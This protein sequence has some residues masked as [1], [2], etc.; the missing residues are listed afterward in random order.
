M[1]LYSGISNEA[2]DDCRRKLRPVAAAC[3]H[4]RRFLDRAGNGWM[5]IRWLFR[6]EDGCE[7]VR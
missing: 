4:V 5:N 2:K 3:S 1:D 7:G 6:C